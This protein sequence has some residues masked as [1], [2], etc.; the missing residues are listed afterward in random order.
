MASAHDGEHDEL[1]LDR[2]ARIE[3]QIPGDV[4][5]VPVDPHASRRRAEVDERLTTAP[6]DREVAEAKTIRIACG[7]DELPAGPS[8]DASDLEHVGKVGG[9]RDLDD[10]CDRLRVKVLNAHAVVEA[11]GDEHRPP[12]VQRVLRDARSV[13][14]DTLNIRRTV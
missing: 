12:Y 1:Q 9:Q 3:A 8:A 2:L 5:A 4:D 14:Q 10:G 11:I 7:R 13:P 6:V